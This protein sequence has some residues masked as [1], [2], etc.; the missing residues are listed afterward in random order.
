MKDLS[1]SNFVT[2]GDKLVLAQEKAEKYWSL[3]FDKQRENMQLLKDTFDAAAKH[4]D[5][6]LDKDGNVLTNTEFQTDTLFDE[7][8][9]NQLRD[10]G[11]D[12]ENYLKLDEASGQWKLGEGIDPEDFLEAVKEAYK[13]TGEMIPQFEAY[14]QW[15]ENEFKRAAQWDKGD[16]SSLIN[17]EKGLADANSVYAE[18]ERLAAGGEMQDWQKALPNWKNAVNNIQKASNQ[19]VSDIL[20]KGIDNIDISDY[21]GLSDIDLSGSLVDVVERYANQAGKTIDEVNDLIMQA[22]EK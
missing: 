6:S 8:E 5:L 9:Y 3:W 11:L 18:L 21:K 1:F 15:A 2:D 16:Y 7:D 12:V 13:K 10:L 19:L 4:Y 22:V 17:K 20:S 14:I